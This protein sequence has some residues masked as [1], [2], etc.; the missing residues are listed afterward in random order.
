MD[1]NKRL[2]PRDSQVLKFIEDTKVTNSN[3]IGKAFFKNLHP[4]VCMRR[5]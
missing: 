2:Q 5:L 4:T 1:L 3:Q